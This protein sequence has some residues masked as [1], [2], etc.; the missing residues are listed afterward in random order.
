LVKGLKKGRGK[1]IWLVG[2]S[3]IIQTF[4][5]HD[6]IDEFIISVHPIILGEGIPLF[7]APLPMTKLSFHHS[8]AFDTGL[9]QLTYVF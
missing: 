8:L 1:D 9:V 3:E 6:L 4:M 2:G 7:C 5:N